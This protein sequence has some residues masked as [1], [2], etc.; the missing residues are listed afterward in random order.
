MPYQPQP[1]PTP[2]RHFRPFSSVATI[3]ATT[4][5]E[6]LAPSSASRASRSLRLRTGR[7]G[8][9]HLDRRLHV[10][11]PHR[12]LQREWAGYPPRAEDGIA[13]Q[14]H[15]ERWAGRSWRPKDTR[16][17][18]GRKERE[19]GQDYWAHRSLFEDLDSTASR[20]KNVGGIGDN[21]E[22]NISTFGFEQSVTG[23]AGHELWARARAAQGE[24][25]WKPTPHLAVDP[26]TLGVEVAARNAAERERIVEAWRGNTIESSG[27]GGALA[28]FT[29]GGDMAEP[30]NDLDEDSGWRPCDGDKVAQDERTA[31]TM[32]LAWRLDERWRY[33]S[34][35]HH[36]DDRFLLDD[37]QPKYVHA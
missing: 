27:F 32:D 25:G 10:T 35:S 17:Q 26:E 30:S 13:A 24:D 9:L 15:A 21:H 22:K 3:S 37:Y 6:G 23:D 14:L 34:E 11:K 5:D 7:G 19:L 36:T 18:L 33:D 29:D 16:V 20:V 12:L 28:L 1:S 4:N 31:D 8:R 2:E